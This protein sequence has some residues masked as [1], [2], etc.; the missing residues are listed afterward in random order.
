MRICW[1]ELSYGPR[2]SGCLGLLCGHKALAG[3]PRN[4]KIFG[5]DSSSRL[6]R[7]TGGFKD[8][9][10]VEF[11]IMASPRDAG[12]QLSGKEQAEH[13]ETMPHHDRHASDDENTFEVEEDELPPGYFT[14]PF[15]IGSM[16]GIG[17]GL[18]AGV[19]GFGYAAPI[20][21]IINNDIGPVSR[22]E[23]TMST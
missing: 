20:L 18:M 16:T 10:L 19:A 8:Q 21:T 3:G 9:I 4:K 14:S 15:F 23:S 6:P 7:E 12:S 11:D 2:S 13:T 17:L 1:T 22:P 5:Q